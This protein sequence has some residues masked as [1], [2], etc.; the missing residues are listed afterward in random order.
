MLTKSSHTSVVKLTD[1]FDEDRGF[2]G[3]WDVEAEGSASIQLIALG[4]VGIGELIVFKTALQGFDL[5][6]EPS[7][8]PGVCFL[9]LTDS[10]NNSAQ[11]SDESGGIQGEHVIEEGVQ[12]CGRD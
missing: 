9:G 12:R 8:L 7:G 4:V 11:Y 1:S 3:P 2:V 6:V 10:A 5:S